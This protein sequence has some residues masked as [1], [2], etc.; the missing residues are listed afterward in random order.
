MAKQMIGVIGLGIMGGAMAEALLAAGHKVAGYDVAPS[1]NA[2]LRKAGGRT[3]ASAGAVAQNA[4]IVITSL[5]RTDGD[6]DFGTTADRLAELVMARWIATG[7]S[8]PSLS[9]QVRPPPPVLVPRR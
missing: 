4:D 2:R 7:D 8:L 1:A 9:V 6:G 5:Q 3:L